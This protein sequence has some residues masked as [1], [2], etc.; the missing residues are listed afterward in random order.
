MP[1]K[2]K[3]RKQVWFVRG[4]PIELRAEVAA[5][6][7]RA[8]MNIGPWVTRVL[9]AA[10]ERPEGQGTPSGQEGAGDLAERVAALAARVERLEA[11]QAV[12]AIPGRSS[13]DGGKD[14]V[15]PAI[16]S[17]QGSALD[18]IEPAGGAE[19]PEGTEAHPGSCSGL[20]AG[21][22]SPRPWTDADD[23]QLRR[24]AERGGTQA[25]AARELG[26]SDGMI[27][28][29][30]KALGLPVPPRKGRKLK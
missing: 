3:P 8:G 7:E 13:G 30:W 17:R 5:A 14:R 10:L 16:P 1:D 2:E 15:P 28:E 18:A 25:D 4:V 20:L 27:N 22:R 24:V 6:A 12:P 19:M 29:H 23:A 9:R 11:V 26:R 21:R